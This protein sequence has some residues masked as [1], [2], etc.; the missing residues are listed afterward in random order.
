MGYKYNGPLREVTEE[1]PRRRGQ[2]PG[3]QPFDPSL[4]G[5]RKG[6]QQHRRHGQEACRPCK[7]AAA[8]YKK[9]WE[10]E[11]KDRIIVKGF[12]PSKCGTPAGYARHTYH[13]VQYCDPC[14]AANAKKSQAVRDQ[15]KAPA[16]RMAA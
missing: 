11:N 16:E 15:A 10:A 5:Q 7:D 9:A 3:L 2:Q 12:N 1:E 6:Y 13:G 14:R 8:A 4:C